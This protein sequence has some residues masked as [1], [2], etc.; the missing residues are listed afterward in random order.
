MK[1]GGLQK[2]SLID[3]PGKIACTICLSGCDFKCKYCHNPELVFNEI[4]NISKDEILEFLEKRI[5]KL[6]GVCISGGEPLIDLDELIIV[7]VLLP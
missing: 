2:F 1:I 5:G 6:D 4:E 7:S 3:F